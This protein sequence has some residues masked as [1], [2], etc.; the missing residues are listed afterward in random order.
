[1]RNTLIGLKIIPKC[2]ILNLK[3]ILE[4]GEEKISLDEAQEVEVMTSPNN[5]MLEEIAQD[6]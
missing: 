4:G 5:R 1:M 2:N 3:S 6:E